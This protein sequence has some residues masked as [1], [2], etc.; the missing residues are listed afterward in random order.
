MEED[1]E[2]TRVDASSL[3]DAILA[4][5]FSLL[6]AAERLKAVAAVCRRWRSVARHPSAW[7]TEA[8]LLIDSRR[9]RRSGAPT[10]GNTVG[11]LDDAAS[12]RRMPWLADTS[13]LTLVADGDE[14]EW[15]SYRKGPALSF[16]SALRFLTHLRICGEEGAAGGG[17]RRG[18]LRPSR[19]VSCTASM[20]SVVAAACPALA[21]VSL[22][23]VDGFE[24]VAAALAPLASLR[25][26]D[27]Q[28]QSVRHPSLLA[29]RFPALRAV[30]D[31]APSDPEEALFLGRRRLLCH[32]VLLMP[33]RSW[34]HEFESPSDLFGF[35]CRASLQ[36]LSAECIG[37][38]LY[39]GILG[40]PSLPHLRVLSLYCSRGVD[41]PLPCPFLAALGGAPSLRAVT[42]GEYTARSCEELAA[43]L[44][45][46]LR[47]PRL[48]TVD[49]R[50]V[51]FKG[52][53]AA[54][55]RAR[56]AGDGRELSRLRL[57]L[58]GS[59]GGDGSGGPEAELEAAF[60]WL[61]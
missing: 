56:L 31:L 28:L 19:I 48:S 33:Q 21:A 40:S 12:L 47:A 41:E 59:E 54:A 27:L 35:E 18:E 60:A 10:A 37:P 34:A 42:L 39:P 52:F 30:H 9:G 1:G 36:V 4:R 16:L 8:E 44:R 25:E 51:A 49:L 3:P 43:A 46:L 20:L 14:R 32:S 7:P 50:G 15:R 23:P 26:V 5:V 53:D 17:G 55:L 13:K 22:F 24:R 61:T 57:P 11:P 58:D 38:A 6:S 2:R 29:A 45:E